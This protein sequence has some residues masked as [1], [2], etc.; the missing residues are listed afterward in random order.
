MC[1]K[2]SQKSGFFDGFVMHMLFE[3]YDYTLDFENG[4][5]TFG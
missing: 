2:F 4:C 1:S 5:C 3:L